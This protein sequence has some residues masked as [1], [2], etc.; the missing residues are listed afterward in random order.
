MLVEGAG[1]A[2]EIGDD[3]GQAKR[4]SGW[5]KDEG[6]VDDGAVAKPAGSEPRMAYRTRSGAINASYRMMTLPVL[7]Q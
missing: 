7:L 6:R 1:H 2:D 4:R 3:G 5:V